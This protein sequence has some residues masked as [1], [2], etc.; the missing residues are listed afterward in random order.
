MYKSVLV[1]EPRY[2]AEKYSKLDDIYAG[3]KVMREKIVLTRL[4]PG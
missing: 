3:S 1:N 4:L 2:T